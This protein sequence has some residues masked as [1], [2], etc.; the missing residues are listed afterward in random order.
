MIEDKMKPKPPKTDC[1]MCGEHD[2]D[3]WMYMA[4]LV[5]AEQAICGKC[6]VKFGEKIVYQFREDIKTLTTPIKWF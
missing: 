6:K 2:C 4:G 1:M 5:P 3:D